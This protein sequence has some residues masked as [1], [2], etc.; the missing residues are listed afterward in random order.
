[1]LALWEPLSGTSSA[2]SSSYLRE[3]PSHKK[4]YNLFH[5]FSEA[6]VEAKVLFFLKRRQILLLC[7]RQ[8]GK[9][10][11]PSPPTLSKHREVSS[12]TFA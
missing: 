7:N 12:S 10:T 4:I 6:T 8:Q 9:S 1:M 3:P 5:V 11:P 2:T